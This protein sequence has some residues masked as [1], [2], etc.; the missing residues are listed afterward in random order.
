MKLS[1]KGKFSS[2]PSLM[3]LVLFYGDDFE[4]YKELSLML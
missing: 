4:D 3:G 1:D 2:L